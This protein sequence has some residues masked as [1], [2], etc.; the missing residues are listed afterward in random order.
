MTVNTIR[1]IAEIIPTT[2]RI[3]FVFMPAAFFKI[4]SSQKTLVYIHAI[5]HYIILN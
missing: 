5:I 1:K 3:N 4:H 2:L